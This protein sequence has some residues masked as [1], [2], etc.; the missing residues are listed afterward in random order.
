MHATREGTS[1]EINKRMLPGRGQNEDMLTGITNTSD[2]IRAT[3]PRNRS[4]TKK[5]HI[6][7]A[8]YITFA[9]RRPEIFGVFGTKT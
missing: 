5:N 9:G 4:E 7:G 3:N 8:L 2:L 1:I 6:K